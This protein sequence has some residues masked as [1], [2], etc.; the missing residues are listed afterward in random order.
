M[1][2]VHFRIEGGKR[3]LE[4]RKY[5]RSDGQTG[6]HWLMGL[7]PRLR[8][9]VKLDVHRDEENRP[10]SSVLHDLKSGKVLKM[11]AGGTAVVERIDGI[12]SFYDIYMEFIDKVSLTSPEH[13]AI[14]FAS[15]ESAGMLDSYGREV[16]KRGARGRLW[17]IIDKVAFRSLNIP[18]AE[19]IVDSLYQ[20][21]H[22]LFHPVWLALI[23]LFA[24]S[25]FVPLFQEMS[26]VHQLISKPILV[27]H[28]N[29]LILIELYIMMTLVAVLHEFAYG[30]LASKSSSAFWNLS[31]KC[32]TRD[33]TAPSSK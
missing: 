7:T 28:K 27:I 6:R 32:R 26:E 15:L 9:G 29:P 4:M 21:V 8:N 18:N 30:L 23:L 12:H 17:N 5:R 13:L 16:K 20:Q 3:V 2:R 22:W 31:D 10:V 24:L 25:G 1:D 19:R 33:W 11:D 14:I